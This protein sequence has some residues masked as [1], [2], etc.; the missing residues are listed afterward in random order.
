MNKANH[1]Y[2]QRSEYN[3]ISVYD[4][5][6]LYGEK[7]SFRVLKFANAEIQGAMDLNRP[8]RIVFE[9]P[10]AIIHLMEHNDP[11]LDNVFMIG[12]GIGTI[13]TY[14]ADKRVKVAELDSLVYDVSRAFFDYRGENV[15]IGDGRSLLE[16]EQDH[17]F[18]YIV[19]D[20]FNARGTPL[21]LLSKPFF[22]LVKMKLISGGSVILNLVGRGENDSL[23]K[24]IATTLRSVFTTTQAFLLPSGG[25]RDV[26]NVLLMGRNGP[27]TYLSKQMAGFLPIHIGQGHLIRDENISG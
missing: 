12:H 18:D 5:T 20:A 24:A 14:F 16:Q 10:R 2:A 17:A 19:L 26:Q 3:E 8:K 13:A 7:G 15:V 21:H 25:K 9:Y 27:I 11:A 1:L 6:E 22:E 23:V 4:T